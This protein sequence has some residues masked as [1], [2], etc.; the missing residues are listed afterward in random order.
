VISYHLNVLSN[1]TICILPDGKRW[2]AA[3]RD[4]TGQLSGHS[5]FSDDYG[6]KLDLDTGRERQNL[7]P[8]WGYP[9]HLLSLKDG[10]LL[11]TYGYRK[12]P[13][14]IR[15]CLSYDKG[16]TWDVEHEIILR[17]DGKGEG[18][19]GYPVSIQLEDGRIF[20]I[21]YMQTGSGQM[22]EIDGNILGIAGRRSDS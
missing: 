21:Y 19:L 12:D 3:I 10:S 22:P 18:D 16:A 15:A 13:L 4:G 6:K 2:I 5:S 20:S 17:A 1:Q 7:R 14:G 9:A 11:C 8:I